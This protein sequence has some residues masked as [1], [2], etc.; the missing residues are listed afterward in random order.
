MRA[1]PP[2]TAPAGSEFRCGIAE[3]GALAHLVGMAVRA[4]L[5]SRLQ[6]AAG[7]VY[8]PRDQDPLDKYGIRI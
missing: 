6:Y 1:S 7:R 2:E 3:T 8:G 4:V 5:A